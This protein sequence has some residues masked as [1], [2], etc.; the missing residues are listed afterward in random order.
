MRQ[1]LNGRWWMGAAA[2]AV[3]LLSGCEPTR[4]VE[5]GKSAQESRDPT[6]PAGPYGFTPGSV[7]EDF[8]V[9]G[10]VDKNGDGSLLDDGLSDIYLSDYRKNNKAIVITAS[11]EWCKPCNDEQPELVGMHED[12]KSKGVA[13]LEALVQDKDYRPSDDATLKRW[14]AKHG[15]SFDLALDPTDV[16]GKYYDIKAFPF[17]MVIRAS[18]MQIVWAANGARPAEIRAAVD[19]ILAEN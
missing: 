2:A 8:F 10:R 19:S 5:E 1:I 16:L 4:V 15:M 18:D 9:L 13:F 14:I 17:G 3:S 11:A 12:Y 6:Y 7:I